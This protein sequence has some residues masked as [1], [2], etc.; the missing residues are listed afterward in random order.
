MADMRIGRIHHV[1][2]V[3]GDP[4]RNL[5]FYEGVLGL[6]LVKR[7]VNFDAPGTH[8]LYYGDET[9]TPGSLLTFFPHPEARPGRPGGGQAVEVALAVPPGAIAF[10][11]DRLQAFG[12][13]AA[14][15]EAR[16]GERLLGL[17]DPDGLRLELVEDA[18]AAAMPGRIAAGV[19]GGASIRGLHGVTLWVDV[20]APTAA[21][22]TGVLGYAAGPTEG[23]RKRFIHPGEGL[24]RMLDIRM[25]AGLAPGAV[26]AGSVHHLAFRAADDDRQAAAARAL[27]GL[28]LSVTPQQDRTYF[29]SVYAREPGGVL[30]EVATDAPGFTVDE[31]PEALGSALMLPARYAP[32]RAA[33]EAALP[34]LRPRRAA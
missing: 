1:T 19:P 5:A 12:I 2:A 27:S 15:P 3:A 23:G 24:G 9:G 11:R 13:A 8:H 4:A 34:P 10:W 20:A 32:H 7:T 28:G 30:F 22:L 14:A 18:A 17:R 26:G 31:A 6:R 33:I 16:F 21:V 29:R 25:V